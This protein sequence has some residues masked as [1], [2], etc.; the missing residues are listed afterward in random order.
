MPSNPFNR[1]KP[2]PLQS[3]LK[4]ISKARNAVIIGQQGANI[5]KRALGGTSAFEGRTQRMKAKMPPVLNWHFSSTDKYAKS[6]MP[7]L[8]EEFVG[9]F[10]PFKFKS[11][12]KDGKVMYFRATLT[13]ISD[14]IS[15]EWSEEKYIG[16]PDKVRVYQGTDRTISFNFKIFPKTVRDLEVQWEKLNYLVSLCYPEI[17]D[18]KQM[19]GPMLELTIGDMFADAPGYL[20]SLTI[21][22]DDN[23]SWEIKPHLMQVPQVIG[24]S[25]DYTYIGKEKLELG[26]LHYATEKKL[27]LSDPG[28]PIIPTIDE[29]DID[30][31]PDLPVGGF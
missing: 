10:I 24:V 13:G 18:A 19:T 16:R 23:T 14:S 21:D 3:V 4:T 20:N 26:G 8:D 9:D 1:G 5:L 12:N 25:C 28:R 29:D 11:L 30:I 2:K 22:V 27:A 6:E 7:R 31:L 17:N 15:P